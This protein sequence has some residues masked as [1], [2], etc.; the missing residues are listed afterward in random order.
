M[1]NE[2]QNCFD[3][4]VEF[5]GFDTLVVHF[6]KFLTTDNVEMRIEIMNFFMKHKDKFNKS[7]GENVY[8]EMM[9]PLLVCLQDRSANVR[10]AAEEIIKISL[11]YNPIANYYKKIEDFKPAI[12]KTLKQT[13]DKIKLEATPN[14]SQQENNQTNESETNS[15]TNHIITEQ[16]QNSNINKKEN[17]NIINLEEKLKILESENNSLKSQLNISLEKEKL[18]NSTVEKIKKIQAENEKSYF[19]SLKE[20]KK[21]EEEIQQKFLNFQKILEDQYGENEKRLTEEINQLT[22]EISK[23]DNII[24]TY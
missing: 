23:R 19:D 20:N 7:T 9:N 1:R 24:N 12:A 18:Y 2:C 13:L 5:A 11:V 21:R 8:K 6:P 17:A 10:N 22:K 16:N 3:K 15:V 4:W 14:E